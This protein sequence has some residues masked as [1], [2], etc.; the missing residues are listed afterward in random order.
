MRQF[1]C[2]DL[3]SSIQPRRDSA[4]AASQYDCNLVVGE[5]FKMFQQNGHSQFWFQSRYRRSNRSI[6]F[7]LDDLVLNGPSGF[8]NLIFPR[9]VKRQEPPK[10]TL[11]VEARIRDH[12][13]EPGGKFGPAFELRDVRQQ[14]EK[15]LLGNVMGGRLVAVEVI[16]RDGI[17]TI[18][19]NLE[20]QAKSLGIA[21]L[22]RFD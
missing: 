22:A 6:P 2:E 8:G 18:L 5:F 17:N 7:A 9:T 12:S 16:E 11:P 10:R 14:L 21:A 20:E 19:V 3:M 1:T 4:F 13:V 15:D